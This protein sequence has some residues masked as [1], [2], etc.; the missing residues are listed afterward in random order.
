MLQKLAIVYVSVAVFHLLAAAFRDRLIALVSGNDNK[1]LGLAPAVS[2][3]R[4]CRAEL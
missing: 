4:R 3:P 2:L 1:V